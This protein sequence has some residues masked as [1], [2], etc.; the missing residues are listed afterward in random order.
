MSLPNASTVQQPELVLSLHICYW[1][2]ANA[3]N[4][5]LMKLHRAIMVPS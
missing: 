4:Y 1:H 3:M 2:A 5:L